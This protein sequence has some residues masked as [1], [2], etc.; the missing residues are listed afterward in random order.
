M[1]PIEL[2][3]YL[4]LDVMNA[5]CEGWHADFPDDPDFQVSALVK[6]LVSEGKLG[7]KTKQGLYKY[8]WLLCRDGIYLGIGKDFSISLPL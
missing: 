2:A 1:G 6:K 7:R 3:D 5:I 8:E 4:G